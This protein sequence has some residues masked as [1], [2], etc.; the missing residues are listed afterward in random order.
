MEGDAQS[1]A[2]AAFERTRDDGEV[3][4]LAIFRQMGTEDR[5]AVLRLARLGFGRGL[6]GLQ[7]GV[8]DD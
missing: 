1:G 4:L 2:R 5:D 8:K 6:A 7:H 3:E